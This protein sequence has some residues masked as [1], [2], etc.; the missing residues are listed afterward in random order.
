MLYIWP[1]HAPELPPA[2]LISSMITLASARPRPEPPYSVGI[3]DQGRQPARL[4]QRVDELLRIAAPL[5]HLAV[6]L[7]GKLRAQ[8]ADRVTNV[9]ETV[10]GTAEHGWLQ[11]R[12]ARGASAQASRG[13]EAGTIRNPRRTRSDF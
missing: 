4:G 2:R 10:V 3:R 8:V 11:K 12:G 7:V 1:W 6:V 13:K 9:L 5:V